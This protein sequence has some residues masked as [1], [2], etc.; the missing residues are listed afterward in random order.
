MPQK[1][2]LLFFFL[3]VLSCPAAA[4]TLDFLGLNGIRFGMKSSEMTGKTIILDSTSAY[5]DTAT[6]I[7][8]TRCLLYFR[9]NE[10]LNLRG[11]KATRVEY[12]FCDNALTYVFVYVKGNAEIDKALNEMKKTFPKLGCKGRKGWECAQI[13]TS[14]KG[15]RLIVNIDRKKEE[16]SFVLIARKTAGH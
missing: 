6:Y 1:I 13:D 3:L 11:F 9:K 16:M 10:N 15:M 2:R 8:N 4:Q 12:E 5:K 14:A 7:R